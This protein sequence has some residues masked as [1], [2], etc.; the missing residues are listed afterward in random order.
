MKDICK[1]LGD[2]ILILMYFVSGCASAEE[3]GGKAIFHI[4]AEQV[5]RRA[6]NTANSTIL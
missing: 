2:T 6:S 3:A 4:I 1:N 5:K